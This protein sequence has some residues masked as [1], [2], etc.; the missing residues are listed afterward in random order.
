MNKA[1]ILSRL[2]VIAITNRHLSP[3][4]ESCEAYLQAGGKAIMLREKDMSNAELFELG[5]SLRALTREA[6]AVLLINDR[7]EVALACEADGAHI[8]ERSIPLQ[9]ARR[10]VPENFLLGFSCHNRR[11]M[12][13]AKEDGA[14]Y[15]SISPIFFPRSKESSLPPLGIPGLQG[16][17]EDYNHPVIALGGITPENAHQVFEAGVHGVAAI[18]SFFLNG[19]CEKTMREFLMTMGEVS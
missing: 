11:E 12:D 1:E 10:I 4:L 6:G 2:Q 13:Q 9:E 18:G 3:I 17:L 15:V 14:D 5:K 8:G 16:M 7:I 19:E